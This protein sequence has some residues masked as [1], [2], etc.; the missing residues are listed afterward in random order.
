MSKSIWT[1]TCKGKWTHGSGMAEVSKLR[2]DDGTRYYRVRVAGQIRM[3]FENESFQQA[4]R[5][6]EKCLVYE[7][8]NS[9]TSNV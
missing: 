9:T 8:N 7:Q 1:K 2:D 5:Y 6:A 4:K 3:D